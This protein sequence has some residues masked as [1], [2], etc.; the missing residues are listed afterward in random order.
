VV[1][2][3][4]TTATVVVARD[5]SAGP[6]GATPSIGASAAPAAAKPNIV[7]ILTD[8]QRWDEL[9]TMPTVE[10][11]IVGKGVTFANG[12]VVNPLCCPSRTT[13]LTGKYSHSTDIYW[14]NPPHGG[15]PTF[16]PEE[17]STVATWLHDAGYRTALIGKYLNHY[18]P[19]NATHVPPGWDDW[20]AEALAGTGE[21]NGG[22]YNYDISDN[23]TLVHHGS[24]PSDYS[25]D[26]FARYATDFIGST[27][28]SQPLFL[29]LAPRA[30]HVPATPPPRYEH[31]C[32]GLPPLRPPSYNEADVSDTPHSVQILPP[33]SPQ[34]QQDEDALHVQHCQ[35]LLAVD[36]AVRDI[37]TALQ[38]TGRLSNT[39]IVFASDNGLQFGEHRLISKKVPYEASIR[40]PIVVRYDPITYSA[41]RTDHHLAL[42]LDFAPTFADAGGVAAPGAVG[43]SLLPLLQGGDVT[44]RSDFL[45]EHWEPK[46]TPGWVPA[47]CAVRT[48]RDVYVEYITGEQELYVLKKDP[49]EL[50]NLAADSAYA[51]LLRK[52]HA[53]MLKLCRPPPPHFHP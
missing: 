2:A 30:P 48:T 43:R 31:A 51:N 4:V 47:Y 37:L 13:I 10:K 5:G 24:D 53:Q 6:A 50:Q 23:G 26:V 25:T 1:L 42:N 45:V 52:L 21:G 44:W 39:L 41:A 34:L 12:F 36:D 9:G 19:K 20:K 32:A 40:V 18:M 7:L 49:D 29:Y 27:P 8:D 3:A 16:E 46:S 38:D 22:Y 33:M 14:N 17:G 28:D 11:E 15:F 35:T